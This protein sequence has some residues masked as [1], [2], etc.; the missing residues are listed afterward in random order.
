MIERS[1]LLLLACLLAAPSPALAWRSTSPGGKPSSKVQH[2]EPKRAATSNSAAR[3]GSRP[4]EEPSRLPPRPASASSTYTMILYNVNTRE[5]LDDLP[6]LYAD[7][8]RPGRLFVDEDA[9][10]KLEVFTRDHRHG[11]RVRRGM[12][13]ELWYYLYVLARH[14]DGPIH[15]VSGYRST[16][17]QTSRH[18]QGKAIDFFIPGVK[19]IEIWRYAKQRFTDRGVGLGYYPNSGFVHLDIRDLSF[20]WIDDSGRGQPPRYRA[21]VK[22]PKHTADRKGD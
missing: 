19:T 1:S 7:P 11:D 9:R 12:P 13:D 21:G 16:D 17:R 15:V 3:A 6:V 20:Y 2:P 5:R 4:G 14:F 10:R 22:Q 18:R 8:A